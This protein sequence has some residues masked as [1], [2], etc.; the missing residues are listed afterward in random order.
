MAPGKPLGATTPR[1]YAER[2]R[3]S[4]YTCNGGKSRDH[5]SCDQS[6]EQPVPHGARGG[7]W[8]QGGDGWLGVTDEAERRRW[9]AG[10][11]ARSHTPSFTRGRVRGNPQP[12][13]QRVCPVSSPQHL[14]ILLKPEDRPCQ[15]ASDASLIFHRRPRGVLHTRRRDTRTGRGTLSV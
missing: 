9:G 8:E 6:N 12:C 7:A 4:G 10:P 11:P 1:F 14:L 3:G 13:G 15:P 2:T 5:F